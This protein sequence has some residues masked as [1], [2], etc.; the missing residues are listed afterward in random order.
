[1]LNRLIAE[2]MGRDRELTD[3][4]VWRRANIDR[5][6]YHKTKKPKYKPSKNTALCLAIALELSLDVTLDL[7]GRAGYALSPSSVRDLIVKYYI[8]EGMYD[9]FAINETLFTYDQELLGAGS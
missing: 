8:T 3:A 1:M 7:L 4:A 5:R 2:R 6:V 9:I